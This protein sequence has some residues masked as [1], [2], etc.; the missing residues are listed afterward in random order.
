MKTYK[1]FDKDFKCGD[2][3][4]IVGEKHT[5]GGKTIKCA[6]GGFHSCTSPIDVFNYY[7]P[8]QSR[9]AV[10]T[11]GGDIDTDDDDSKVVSA[12]IIVEEEIN[13]L[14][15]VNI[16]VKH[17]VDN[18]ETKQTN[19]G[20]R[21][22]ATNTGGRSAA[23]NTGNQSAATNTGDDSAATNTGYRSA[24]TNTGYQSAATNTGYQSAATN[25]GDRSAATNTG[26]RSAA[27]NT[28]YRSA[29]TN[30]GDRSA[31][32]NTGDYSVAT[33]TGNQSAA[34]VE[35]KHSVACGVGY[36]NKVRGANGCIIFS[37]YRDRDSDEITHHKSAM[38]GVDVKADTWYI[39]NSDG[40][41]EELDMQR[42][43]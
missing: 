33:N 40:D 29:A 17:I 34:S 11:I 23:T 24:A 31:A 39:L 21:S 9:F 20:G 15:F 5:F 10:C 8:V 18:C 27:T 2:F 25:T 43:N 42:G 4:Y 7:P 6:E 37:V 36:E 30:T 22:A 38:C 1:G 19:T 35:G 3:Q 26:Y 13:L 14:Q 41:F 16:C 12:E 32:T 28:G